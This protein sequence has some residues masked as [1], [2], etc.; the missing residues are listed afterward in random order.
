M[1]HIGAA[2][3][4]VLVHTGYSAVCAFYGFIKFGPNVVVRIHVLIIG[5][6]IICYQG[7]FFISESSFFTRI[8]PNFTVA[9]DS[10]VGNITSAIRVCFTE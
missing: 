7:S 3:I 6:G 2:H 1:A 10:E 9:I 4:A 8:V 5:S